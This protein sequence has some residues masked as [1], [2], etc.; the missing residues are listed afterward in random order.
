VTDGA[1]RIDGDDVRDLALASI[2]EIC[3]TVTQDSYL[4]HVNVRS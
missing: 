1:V 2:S 3:G 4:F